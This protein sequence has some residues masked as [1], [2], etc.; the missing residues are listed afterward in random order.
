[1]PEGEMAERFGIDDGSLVNRYCRQISS[2]LDDDLL[3][4]GLVVFCR[5]VN[6]AS[7]M[8]EAIARVQRTVLSKVPRN[9]QSC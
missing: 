1:M 9:L 6:G 3:Q 4:E 7:S 8:K 5:A 2:N